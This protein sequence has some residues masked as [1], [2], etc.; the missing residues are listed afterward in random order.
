MPPF[1][2]RAE[3]CLP[4]NAQRIA[5]CERGLC[6]LAAR[7]ARPSSIITCPSGEQFSR[8]L[9]CPLRCRGALSRAVAWT[10][11]MMACR[12]CGLSSRMARS[13]TLLMREWRTRA[14]ARP[15]PAAGRPARRSRRRRGRGDAECPGKSLDQAFL[16]VLRLAVAQLPDGGVAD[17]PPVMS[18]I[19]SATSLLEKGPRPAGRAVDQPVDLVRQG[20]Q[21]GRALFAG[22]HVH[23]AP[24]HLPAPFG[25]SSYIND[26]S[27]CLVLKL[28]TLCSR[29]V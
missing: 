8:A 5:R 27:S 1:R 3:H 15:A 18:L 22:G 21:D 25:S 2:A 4:Q 9:S 26:H 11:L 12:A 10:R 6:F 7:P 14:R 19:R 24:S 13:W 29:A 20:A 16:R 28:T 23:P 17:V